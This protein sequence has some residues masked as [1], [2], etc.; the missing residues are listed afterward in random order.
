MKNYEVMFIV[1]PDLEEGVI[2]ETVKHLKEI[3]T[4]KNATI[5]EEKD[6]GTKEL[7]Y[8]INKYNKGIYYWFK[9]SSNADAVSEFDRVAGIN[10]NVLR[11]IVVG[12]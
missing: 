5:L 8:E 1:K 10:E 9:V 7:A 2:V 12:E 6:M 3:F 4:S 11:F